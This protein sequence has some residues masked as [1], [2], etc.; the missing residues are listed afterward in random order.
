MLEKTPLLVN[1]KVSETNEKS[2]RP[3]KSDQTKGKVIIVPHSHWDRGKGLKCLNHPALVFPAKLVRK[4]TSNGVE[5]PKSERLSAY[6]Y[7]HSKR[8]ELAKVPPKI[9]YLRRVQ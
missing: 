9:T 5:K 6:Q 7:C 3:A 1:R 8:Q 2:S 4:V